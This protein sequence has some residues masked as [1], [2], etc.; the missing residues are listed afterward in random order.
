MFLASRCHDARWVGPAVKTTAAYSTGHREASPQQHS[1]RGESASIFSVHVA[2]VPT[3]KMHDDPDKKG[4]PAVSSDSTAPLQTEPALDT[5]KVMWSSVRM[6]SRA[7]AT[8]PSKP[9]ASA[10]LWRPPAR[11]HPPERVVDVVV[12]VDVLVVV[13]V[14]VVVRVLVVLI[15]AVVAFASGNTSLILIGHA[16][17]APQQQSRR[18]ESESRALLQEDIS[19]LKKQAPPVM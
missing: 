3:P 18:T 13:R 7:D 6:A 1:R 15:C 5:A 14:V 16:I 8:Q 12:V 19:L 17:R 9:Q 4:S 10:Q 11:A 2:P